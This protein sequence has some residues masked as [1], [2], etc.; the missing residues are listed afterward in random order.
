MALSGVGKIVVFIIV[1]S[2][3]G[4]GVYV[5]MPAISPA[6]TNKDTNKNP[7]TSGNNSTCHVGE[8][9]N[10][11]TDGGNKMTLSIPMVGVVVA[12]VDVKDHFTMPSNSAR[13]VVNISWD[14]TDWNLNLAI[15][16][17]DCPDNGQTQAEQKNVQTGPVTLEFPQTCGDALSPGQWF[18]HAHSNDATSHRGE[19]VTF[20][21]TVT[22][23]FK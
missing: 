3:V 17:G 12:E 4:A 16:Q 2:V 22:V 9:S 10:L 5:A 20:S 23:Y 14:K 18:V 6:K 7:G 8:G 15:G 21:Y 13:V 11:P 19:S 1:I